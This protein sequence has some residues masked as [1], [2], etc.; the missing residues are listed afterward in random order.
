MLPLLPRLV[1]EAMSGM[2]QVDWRLRDVSVIPVTALPGS[3][4][5]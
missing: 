2:E 4:S 5:R 3:T 1:Q